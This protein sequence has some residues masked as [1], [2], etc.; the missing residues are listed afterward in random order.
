VK[1]VQ[2]IEAQADLDVL[3][4]HFA[5]RSGRIYAEQHLQRVEATL[6]TIETYPKRGIFD[7]QLDIFS[8]WVPRTRFIAFYRIL[9]AQDLIVVL[10]IID[11]ASHTKSKRRRLVA[12]RR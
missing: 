2:H 8:V 11:H 12:S 1:L 3:L 10:A 9:P 5:S 4:A 7:E 6:K